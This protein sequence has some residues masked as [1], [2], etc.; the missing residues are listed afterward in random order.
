MVFMYKT[1]NLVSKSGHTT[2]MIELY[3]FVLGKIDRFHFDD[4]KFVDV[5]QH[6]FN[7][8]KNINFSFGIKKI[9]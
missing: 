2:T 4:E 6:I 5:S 9:N 3:D 8:L 7:R 1:T